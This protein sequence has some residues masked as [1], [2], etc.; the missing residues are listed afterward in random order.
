MKKRSILITLLLGLICGQTFS[1]EK[2]AQISLK[3][4]SHRSGKRTDAT[5]QRW[6]EYGLGQFIHWGIYSIPG[7]EW[8][9]KTYGGAAEWI[10]S[11]S[12]KDAPADWRKTYDNLYKQFNPI[13]FNA[14]KWAQQAKNMG[15]KY[16]IFTTKHHDGFCMWPSKYTEYTIANTPYKKD[17]VKEVVDAYNKVG[18]DVYLYFSVM[19]WSHQGWRYDIKTPEDSIAFESFKKFTRNQL[20]ELLTDYPS[21]KGLWFDGTWDKSWVKQAEFADELET[22]MRTLRPGLIIGSRF[23]ADDFG[24]R[25]VDSNGVMMGDY[26]Q[27]WERNLPNSIEDVHGHD[28][29]CVMTIPDNQWGYNANWKGYVKTPYNLIEMLVKSVSLSGN[30]VI[31]FGP[32]GKGNI[33][34]EET[35]IAKEVG[36]W[37]K[38]NNEAIYGCSHADIKKQDWGY[39]T[40]KGRKLYLTV[41]N[42]PINNC[43][44][45]EISKKGVKPTKAYFLTNKQPVVI[46]DAG[47]NKQNSSLYNIVIPAKYISDKPFVIVLELEE[48]QTNE[49]AY[50]QART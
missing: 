7:G 15:A 26:E 25:H 29:D 4:G 32:D 37:M 45:V 3:H 8:D 22:E 42:R 50:Q 24:K 14:D 20:L 2:T 19:D 41:F 5:M 48:S 1:Q 34:Q 43:L 46:Q 33:R 16:V 47:K 10:R 23:R 35:H 49:K 30:F 18:I 44:N 21:A 40:Q 31:N 38:I 11:W 39:F 13:N 28:W 17:V 12:G 6:R 36:D 27:G 9:G